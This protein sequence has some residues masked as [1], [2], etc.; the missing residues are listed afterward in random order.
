MHLK[1]GTV[2]P[3]LK[4]GTTQAGAPPTTTPVGFL[5]ASLNNTNYSVYVAN[6]S[7]VLTRIASAQ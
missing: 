7:A 1:L 2:L 6:V 3:Y 5:T 4:L